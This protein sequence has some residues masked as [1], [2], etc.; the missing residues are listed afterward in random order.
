MLGLLLIMV[1]VYTETSFDLLLTLIGTVVIVLASLAQAIMLYKGQQRTPF[2][3]SLEQEC[4]RE[5]KEFLI[6]ENLKYNCNGLHWSIG[7]NFYWLELA[8][9]KKQR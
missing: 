7:D 2:L 8:V 4:Q 6:K 1:A 3:M 5:L 9:T